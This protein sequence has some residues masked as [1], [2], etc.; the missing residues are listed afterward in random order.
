MSAEKFNAFDHDLDQN[1]HWRPSVA[2][3][4]YACAE[5]GAERIMQTNHT[6]TVPGARCVGKC[7]E[8]LRPHTENEVVLPKYGP[9]RYIC[10][11]YK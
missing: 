6:G 9:H 8:I 7:R 3:R 2:Y 5:C 4:R 11:A 1:P 10:E